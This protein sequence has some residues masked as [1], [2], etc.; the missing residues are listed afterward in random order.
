MKR[1]SI[2]PA[3]LFS[4]LAPAAAQAA[5]ASGET[6]QSVCYPVIVEIDG[7]QVPALLCIPQGS[8]V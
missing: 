3:L 6:R 1:I 8:V 7:E 2:V 4:L 5:L